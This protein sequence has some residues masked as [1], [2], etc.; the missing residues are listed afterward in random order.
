MTGF[1]PIEELRQRSSLRQHS[2]II[3]W[4]KRHGE[5][6]MR[7]STGEPVVTWD[8]LTAAMLPQPQTAATPKLRLPGRHGQTA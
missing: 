2:A 3:R 1:V 4:L 5:N 8:A 7:S 6:P